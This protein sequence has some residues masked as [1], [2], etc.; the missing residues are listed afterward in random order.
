MVYLQRWPGRCHVKLSSSWRILCTPNYHTPCHF[1]Q[2]HLC[3]VCLAVTCH[4][5]FWQND[6]DLLCATVVKWGWNRYQNKSQHR[7]STLKKKIL[8]PL[9]Q[10]FEPTTFQSQVRHS[11]HWAIPTP[12]VG[13]NVP[14]DIQLM[15]SSD[16]PV[17]VVSP[18]L[19][20]FSSTRAV[21]RSPVLQQQ[22]VMHNIYYIYMYLSL[23]HTYI[24]FANI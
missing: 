14:P 8:L 22:Q 3:K 24:L 10:G 15:C 16:R 13:V 6:R 4:L 1:M 2:G 19:S 17:S 7:K 23:S 21:D 20:S 18:T 11:N 12:T 5:R 9:L